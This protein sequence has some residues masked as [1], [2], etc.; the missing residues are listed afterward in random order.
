MK[1]SETAQINF[2]A[3]CLRKG[4]QRKEILGKFGK[5]WEKVSRTTFDRRLRQAEAHVASEQQRIKD[6]AEQDV[7]KEAD[8]LKSKILTSLERQAILS[9]MAKGELET[10]VLLV[11]KDGIKKAKAKPT[12]AERRAAIAEL[13]KMDGDYAP[14]KQEVNI[15]TPVL[16][17]FMKTNESQS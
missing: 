12:H 6:Q 15:S 9:D 10:E 7:V 5:K 4:E 17:P 2:I 14:T 8:A 16:P 3:D 1:P 13:N 11:T